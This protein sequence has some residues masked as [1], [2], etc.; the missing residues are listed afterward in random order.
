[1]TINKSGESADTTAPAPAPPST[2]ATYPQVGVT[3]SSGV[4]RGGLSGLWAL[5]SWWCAGLC[6]R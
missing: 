3:Y 2:A 4:C 6:G 5:P 1:M